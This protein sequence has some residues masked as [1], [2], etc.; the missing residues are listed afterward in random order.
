MINVE[1]LKQLKKVEKIANFYKW[2]RFL[3]N[4][5]KYLNAILFRAFIYP[6]R[7]QEKII[8]TPLFYNKPIQIALPAAT[9]IYLTG[10]KSHTSEI[11]LA[12][13]LI[14]NLT[15]GQHF[16]DIGAH[17][18]YFTLLAN[19]LVGSTG[20]IM[21]FEPSVDS[22]NLLRE[23]TIVLE[24]ISIFQEAVS[25]KVGELIFYTFPNQYSEYNTSTVEQFEQEAW[26]AQVVSKKLMVKSTSID[27]ITSV[28]DF[29]PAI[30][31]IDV[32]GAEYD[33]I[34]GGLQFFKKNAPS[35]VMEYL[36]PNRKN[37]LHK[38]GV[39]LLKNIGYAT[40]VINDAG[41]LETIIDIDA[42]LVKEQLESDNIVIVKNL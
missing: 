4:P 31:K 15:T 27:T 28:N 25:H 8:I 14:L 6:K 37:E 32:E 39:Q 23:N 10:G 34:K 2:Q 3:Y 38:K 19:E 11:R 40:Y 30:I 33:V 13:Y 36:A 9:D 16:L 26:F 29:N 18:G 41:K 7:Q 24:N 35:I 5:Y 17:Y 20:K 42:Y 22:F 21:A 12:K 1:L